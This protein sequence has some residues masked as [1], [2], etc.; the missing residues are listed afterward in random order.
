M[1][2]STAT[3]E[4][5]TESIV[6]TIVTDNKDLVTAESPSVPSTPVI[7]DTRLDE[8]DTTQPI[9]LPEPEPQTFE[10]DPVAEEIAKEREENIPVATTE[11]AQQ[12]AQER[13]DRQD[14]ADD[15]DAYTTDGIPLTTE[16]DLTAPAKPTANY[17]LPDNAQL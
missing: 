14:L 7:L 6:S 1:I 3:E 16:G 13:E 10:P 9:D 5:T 8:V 15:T 4:S 17:K 11:E 2:Q 12:I